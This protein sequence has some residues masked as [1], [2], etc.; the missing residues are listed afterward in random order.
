MRKCWFFG[1]LIVVGYGCL[2]GTRIGVEGYP[3][4]DLVVRLPGQP[5]VKFSQYAGYVDIDVK[6][7]RSFFYYFVEAEHHPRKKPL[8]LWLNGGN[9]I[10]SNR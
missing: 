6:Y 7:G 5:K 2:L 4:E 10:F 8:T 9:S 3:A 1:V